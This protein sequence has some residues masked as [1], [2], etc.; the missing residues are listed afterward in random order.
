MGN[1]P[2]VY[3]DGFHMELITLMFF[4]IY[5]FEYILAFCYQGLRHVQPLPVLG[6]LLAL[7]DIHAKQQCSKQECQGLC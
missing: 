6:M 5:S 1:G 2:A 7:W 4:C 3:I